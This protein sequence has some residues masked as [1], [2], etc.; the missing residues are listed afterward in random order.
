MFLEGGTRDHFMRWL[1]QEYPQLMEDYTHL[2]SRKYA[3]SDYRRE[4]SSVIGMLKAKYG[5]RNRAESDADAGRPEKEKAGE[6]PA[7]PLTS[8]P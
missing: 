8:D 4:V 6:P 1:A 7:L 3:P 5:L 2:Y